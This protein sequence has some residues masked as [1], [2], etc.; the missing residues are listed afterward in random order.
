ML[1]SPPPPQH[2][3]TFLFGRTCIRPLQYKIYTL[4]PIHFFVGGFFPPKHINVGCFI[5][6]NM[7]PSFTVIKCTLSHSLTSFVMGLFPPSTSLWGFFSGRTCIHPLQYKLYTLTLTYFLL[8][9]LHIIMVVSSL[10]TK[11]TDRANKTHRHTRIHCHTYS[12]VLFCFSSLRIEKC[13]VMFSSGKVRLWPNRPSSVA[14][15]FTSKDTV[16]LIWDGRMEVGEEGYYI[17]ITTLS[18]PE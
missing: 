3:C 4:T 7:H 16:R 17:P 13:S 9:E 12:S 10:Y 5:R 6:K 18:P 11:P 8:I 15:C 2:Q 14:W 1:V